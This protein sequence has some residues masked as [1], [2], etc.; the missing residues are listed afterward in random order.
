MHQHSVWFAWEKATFEGR[1]FNCWEISQKKGTI[2]HAKFEDS[3]GGTVFAHFTVLLRHVDPNALG[4]AKAALYEIWKLLI[5]NLT[6]AFVFD[7]M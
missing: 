4:G 3:G 6:D 2:E 5:Y 7:L 1:E